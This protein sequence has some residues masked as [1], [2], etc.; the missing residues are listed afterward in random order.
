M[1]YKFFTNTSCEYYPCKDVEKLNCLFCYCPLY[2]I[3][4]CGGQPKFLPNGLKDCSQCTKTHGEEG[5]Y[6]IQKR[7]MDINGNIPL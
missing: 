1:S 3:N 5:W 6:W 4:P 7:I 2:Y